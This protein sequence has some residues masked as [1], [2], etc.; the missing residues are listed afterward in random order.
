[1][2]YQTPGKWSQVKISCLGMIFQILFY[3]E[4]LARYLH[5][6]KVFFSAEIYRFLHIQ[7]LHTR[8][9]GP[10]NTETEK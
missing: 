9:I 3:W 6:A 7:S 8:T 4:C 1:M 5:S 10:K 2:A